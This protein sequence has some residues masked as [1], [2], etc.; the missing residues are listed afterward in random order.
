MRRVFHAFTLLLFLV[1]SL[2]TQ[3]VN[4]YSAL[5]QPSA[6]GSVVA[7]GSS[8]P[9]AQHGAPA[10]APAQSKEDVDADVDA[11]ADAGEGE[12]EASQCSCDEDAGAHS[13]WV[14]PYTSD[15]CSPFF[16]SLCLLKSAHFAPASYVPLDE[17]RPPEF[18]VV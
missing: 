18:S 15:F 12:G 14:R 13:E 1:T 10:R 17:V 2:I 11:G 9:C 7:P 8:A 16:L 6:R 5:A 3:T 4:S